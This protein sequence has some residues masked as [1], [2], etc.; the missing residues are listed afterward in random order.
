MSKY[1]KLCNFTEKWGNSGSSNHFQ[2]CLLSHPCYCSLVIAYHS[3]YMN[4]VPEKV[5]LTTHIFEKACHRLAFLP[6]SKA[7]TNK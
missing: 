6:V 3:F 7:C 5:I 1:Q 4:W 2:G